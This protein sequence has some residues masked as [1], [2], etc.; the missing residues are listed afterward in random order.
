LQA[1]RISRV[2]RL[3]KLIFRLLHRDFVSW[4]YHRHMSQQ[5]TS[6]D[7]PIEG[8]AAFFHCGALLCAIGWCF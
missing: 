8:P 1:R 7:V 2:C 3:A 6:A 4:D 5:M